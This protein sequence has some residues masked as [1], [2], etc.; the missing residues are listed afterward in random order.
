MAF[1][2][3]HVEIPLLAP[4]DPV[5]RDRRVAHF[6]RHVRDEA[7]VRDAHIDD[8]ADQPVLRAVIDKATTPLATIERLARH[9]GLDVRE[10]WGVVILGVDGM[11]S[12]QSAQAIEA[13]LAGVPGVRAAASFPSRSLRVE[14][15]RSR[16]QLPEIVLR[17]DRLGYRVR[18]TSA[19]G[20]REGAPVHIAT[21]RVRR[22]VARTRALVAEYPEFATAI[23]AAA[24][25]IGSFAAEVSGAPAL[26]A[27]PGYLASY[28]LAGWHTARDAFVALRRFTFNIDMLMFVAAIGAGALGHWAEGALLLVLF[29]FGHAGE[30]LAMSRARKAIKALHE[31]APETAVLRVDGGVRTVHVDELRIGDVVVVRPGDRVPADG[32]V[33]TGYSSVDQSAIT[34]ES[35]PVEKSVGSSV[36]AGTVNGDGALDVVVEKLSSDTTLARAIRLVEEAQTQKSPTELFTAKVERFYVPLI[37]ACTFGLLIVMPVVGGG[38][39]EDWKTWF[40]RS[41]AFLTAASPC[42]LAIGAPAGVLSALAR[43]ARMGVLIKGGAHLETLGKIDVCAFDKT[44]TLTEGKPRVSRVAPLGGTTEDE[45]LAYAASV[46]SGSAHPLARAVVEA[47]TERGVRIAEAR[48]VEQVVGKGLRGEV[49]GAVVE[50]GSARM[51][52]GLLPGDVAALLS[53]EQD[54]GA[55]PVVVRVDGKPLGVLSLADAPRPETKDAI[56]ALRAAGVRR[57]VMLTGDNEGAAAAVARAVGVDE[58]HSS[59]LPEDKLRIIGEL[60]RSHG[61]V[62]MVGDG[63][64]DAP[65]LAAA[66]VGVAMGAA[67]SDVALETADVALMHDDLS[68]FPDAVRM[69]RYARSIIMQNVVI[70]L[71]VIA[72]LAPLAVVGVA[73]IGWAVV[74]HEGST[75]VVVVNALRILRFNPRPAR[76]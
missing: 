66:S 21:E 6:L 15:D 12:A 26:A 72:V 52:D 74:I 39:F 17:L 11:V 47:A 37:L 20:K 62:A 50:I 71:G 8:S 54:A 7:G 49:D 36:F 42:A 16:C 5:E 34:G 40:Y 2:S 10:R 24:L 25:L 35:A 75:V 68:R 67:G 44:G 22:G 32:S 19:E 38:A 41:M 29:A 23:A 46:E 13:A 31:V 9:A 69:A 14:F 59:L 64:N 1:R 58:H 73:S 48:S 30:D 56:D 53:A 76:L 43:S 55:T 4:D 57:I 61:A 18:A 51:F 3:R 28:V 45:L 70:A 65:A 27:L 60:R 33:R 63:V